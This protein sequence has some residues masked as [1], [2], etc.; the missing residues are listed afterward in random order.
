MTPGSLSF[1]AKEWIWPATAVLV[2][3]L[4]FIFRS[5]AGTNLSRGTRILGFLLKAVGLALLAS[6]LLEPTWTTTRPREGANL[7]GVVADNSMGLQLRDAGEKKM[8]SEILRDILT[9]DQSW[10]TKLDETFLLRRYLFDSRLESTRDYAQLNFQGR[11]SGIGSALK[12]V[13]ERFQ[14]QPL[15]GVLLFTD[16]N[17]TDLEEG[18]Y[19]IPGLPPVYPVLIGKDSDL[20]DIAVDNV[21]A[22]QTIFEDA[23]V[24]LTGTIKAK[25]FDSEKLAAQVILNGKVVAEQTVEPRKGADIPLRFQLKPDEPGLS[26][27]TLRVAHAAGL[28]NNTNLVEATAHNNERIVTV[29]RGR[30]PHRILYVGGRP[31]WEYKFLNRAVSEDPEVQ[32]VSLIRI[33]RRE[34]KFTFRGRTGESSNPLFRGFNK[35]NEETERYDQPVLI[36]LNTRDEVELRSGFPKSAEDLY[37]YEGIILDDMEADF[38]TPD[39]LMLVQRYVSERGGGFL[40]LGGADSLENGKFARTPV[41]DMLPLY[42]DR[43]PQAGPAAAYDNTYKYE[44]TR[45]G[46]LQP[47]MRL[48]STESEER[49]RLD[50]IPPFLVLNQLREIKPGASVLAT[51]T[52]ATGKKF[53]AVAMQRFGN[54]RTAVVAV[55]DLFHAGAE[56]EKAQVDLGKTW[57]QMLRWLIADVP[58]QCEIRMQPAA[59]TGQES[60]VSL[61]VKARDKKFDPLENSAVL[62]TITGPPI[63]GKTNRVTIPAEASDKEAGV[64]RA[65]YVPREPG[66]YRATATITDSTGVKVAEVETG[67]ASEPLA[68]EFASLKPNRPLLEDIARKTGGELLTPERL[69]KFV[70]SLQQKKAPIIETYSYP[71]WHKPFVFLAALAC[72]I[73]EW[74]IRRWKGL[75]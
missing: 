38:F 35:T 15:A 55:G 26:F 24:T 10:Q 45:E 22:S 61:T 69:G 17:A 6:V 7:F 74:G 43:L 46:W 53:P 39:Q 3:G 5:Y 34:P 47:W 9:S 36:R 20:I 52:D 28:Q 66:A 14:G 68:R 71:L 72:F 4:F 59:N 13:S 42:L 48:R 31:N 1:A 30:G 23:P 62:I 12:S 67:W 51:V 25:G 60:A 27:Y 50:S 70:E 58:T 56:N 65:T 11:E 44:L 54:G 18:F 19:E 75:A 2:I 73:S 40:M 64:Y 16:G 21:S 49:S 37:G 29:D 63:D 8:R 41:G 32:L 33:A 57:R